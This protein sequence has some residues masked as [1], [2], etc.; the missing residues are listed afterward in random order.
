MEIHD[1]SWIFKKYFVFFW[2]RVF[3]IHLYHTAKWS[4]SIKLYRGEKQFLVHFHFWGKNLEKHDFSWI[5]KFYFAFFLAA[6]VR[7]SSELYRK[8]IVIHKALWWRKTIFGALPFLRL[9][10]GNT[11]FFVNFQNFVINFLEQPYLFR[12][13]CKPKSC[14]QKPPLQDGIA[15]KINWPTQNF[16]H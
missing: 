15:F 3:G 7:N 12:F 6:R 14:S 9:K 2:P 8:M 16:D 10:F 1:F 5:F 13:S 4:L 11:W